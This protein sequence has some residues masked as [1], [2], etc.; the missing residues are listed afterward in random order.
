MAGLTM[1]GNSTFRANAGDIPRN[2][3][4]YGF[5]DGDD[6]LFSLYAPDQI[7]AEGQRRYERE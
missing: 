5:I 1:N 6:F 7:M 4:A 3:I 2:G